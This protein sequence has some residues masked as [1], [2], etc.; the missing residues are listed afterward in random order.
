[1]ALDTCERVLLICI[2]ILLPY[3]TFRDTIEFRI[4]SHTIRGFLA[5]IYDV[6]AHYRIEQEQHQLLAITEDFLE[7]IH[8]EFWRFEES[9]TFAELV[10]ARHR[11][12]HH[13]QNRGLLELDGIVFGRGSSA[14]HLRLP[15][16]G[17]GDSAGD[18]ENA[19]PL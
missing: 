17:D 3:F 13:L 9:E 1:M 16:D 7:H 11:W 4:A 5:V 6:E 12:I 10:A 15:Y 14:A 8:Y 2:E 19:A 18:F